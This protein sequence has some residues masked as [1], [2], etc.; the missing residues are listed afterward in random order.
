[1]SFLRSE[2]SFAI[3]ASCEVSAAYD[4]ECLL[5]NDTFGDLSLTL[6]PEL[7]CGSTQHEPILLENAK[8]GRIT[9]LSVTY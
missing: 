3:L 2:L 1:M 9:G 6:A 4:P 7:G 5:E 8:V